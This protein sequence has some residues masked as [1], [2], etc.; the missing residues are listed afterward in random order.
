MRPVKEWVAVGK[1]A[2]MKQ[3]RIM[4]AEQCK[5]KTDRMRRREDGENE[6]SGRE[7]RQE[8][9]GVWA[10]KQQGSSRQFR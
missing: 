4:G 5:T 3:E 6:T 10:S 8:V 1:L 9:P 7:C 2:E